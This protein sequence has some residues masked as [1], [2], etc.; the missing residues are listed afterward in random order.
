MCT[1]AETLLLL[2]Y[3]RFWSLAVSRH[4]LLSGVILAIAKEQLPLPKR[5]QRQ[6]IQVD[7]RPLGQTASLIQLG[8]KYLLRLVEAPSSTNAASLQSI[9]TKIHP[10][11]EMVWDGLLLATARERFLLP[12]RRRPQA[13][14][15]GDTE[16]YRRTPLLE[17]LW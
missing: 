15:E 12:D 5:H 16:M 7:A 11:T 10:E 1:S 4:L 3:A 17:L 2:I 8:I 9:V 13:V 14:S 6:A